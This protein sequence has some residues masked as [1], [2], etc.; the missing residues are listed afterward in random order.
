MC[1]SIILAN[2]SGFAAS[3]STSILSKAASTGAKTVTSLAITFCKI[4][5]VVANLDMFNAVQNIVN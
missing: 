2:S 3:L 4:D 5:L 1:N